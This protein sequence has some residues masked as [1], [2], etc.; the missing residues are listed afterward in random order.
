MVRE[1]SVFDHPSTLVP[2]LTKGITTSTINIFTNLISSNIVV[3]PK[4]LYNLEFA[5]QV[6]LSLQQEVP[7][8]CNSLE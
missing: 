2:Y 7:V 1:V 4:R 8:L 3:Y 6:I 5:A